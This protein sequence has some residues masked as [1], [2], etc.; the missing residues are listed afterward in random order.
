MDVKVI[1]NQHL[2]NNQVI[3]EVNEHTE[4]VNDIVNYI[5]KLAKTKLFPENIKG[6]TLYKTRRYYFLSHRK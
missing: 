4:H 6:N 5:N 1:Y 3:I 2:D